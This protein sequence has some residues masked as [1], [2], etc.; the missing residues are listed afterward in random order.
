M[1]LFCRLM[2]HLLAWAFAYVTIIWLIKH[3]MDNPDS[4][5]LNRSR[6]HKPEEI[7]QTFWIAFRLG[8]SGLVAKKLDHAS[9]GEPLKSQCIINPMIKSITSSIKLE[10][11][12]KHVENQR[13]CQNLKAW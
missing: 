3:G 4:T 7:G 12:M 1:E 13:P 9:L 6:C 11:D 8:D 2:L 10:K 5:Q